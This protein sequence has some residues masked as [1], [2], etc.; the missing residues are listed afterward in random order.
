MLQQPC[1]PRLC[2][3]CRIQRGRTPDK[4]NFLGIVDDDSN[5]VG[6]LDNDLCCWREKIRLFKVLVL[7]L[8][9]LP[10]DDMRTIPKLVWDDQGDSLEVSLT[11]TASDT[12]TCVGSERLASR[13]T[14]RN[15]QE[16]GQPDVGMVSKVCQRPVLLHSVSYLPG[17]LVLI[18]D[19]LNELEEAAANVYF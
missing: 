14:S 11:F 15:G 2:L 18:L 17:L 1:E 13:Q 5:V 7:G 8:E 6:G 9:V 4:H 12:T 3:L 19:L 16:D 10:D